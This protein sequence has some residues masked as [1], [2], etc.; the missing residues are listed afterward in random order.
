MAN[1]R[2]YIGARYTIKIYENSQDAGSAEWE[3]NTSY[4]PLVMVTYNNSSYLSKKDV[5]ATI[6]NPALNPLYWIVTGAYNGQIA[7]LQAQIDA[8]N[9]NELPAITAQIQ[10]LS[11]RIDDIETGAHKNCIFIG[12]SYITTITNNWAVQLASLL[13]LTVGTDCFIYGAGSSGFHGQGSFTEAGFIA[14]FRQAISDL[15]TAQKNSIDTIVFGGGHNDWDTSIILTSMETI[16]GLASAFPNAK[17]YVAITDFG[18]V[19]R[20]DYARLTMAEGYSQCHNYDMIYLGDVSRYI[21]KDVLTYLNADLWHVTEAGAGQIAQGLYNAL[22]GSSL[23][24]AM[25]KTI[26]GGY[27][28]IDFTLDGNVIHVQ[29]RS[30]YNFQ[31]A[32]VSSPAF[33]A[34]GSAS[35]LTNRDTSYT[36][37]SSS[38]QTA[39]GSMTI[40]DASGFTNYPCRFVVKDN[41]IRMQPQ[42]GSGNSWKSWAEGGILYCEGYVDFTL[43]LELNQ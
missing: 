25:H 20:A 3:A 23:D 4:E 17:I 40:R 16:K 15:T 19:A 32:G 1:I 6:G 33:T 42:I 14:L 39:M 13:G 38:E 30:M 9:N 12:D 10:S 21:T 43:S 27:G 41:E 34:N 18:R 31:S 5:P 8:I 29:N 37:F 35:L 26:T 36:L 22:K 7:A 2:Q 11:D 24:F 28:N